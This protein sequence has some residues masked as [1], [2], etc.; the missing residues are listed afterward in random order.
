MCTITRKVPGVGRF[1]V[2]RTKQD[3]LFSLRIKRWHVL[4]HR[5]RSLWPSS[6][7]RRG[8]SAPRDSANPAQRHLSRYHYHSLEGP[9]SSFYRYKTSW[10]LNCSKTTVRDINFAV[11]DRL[12]RAKHWYDTEWCRCA[13]AFD[14]FVIELIFSDDFQRRT[15]RRKTKADVVVKRNFKWY[16]YKPLIVTLRTV[17][18]ESIQHDHRHMFSFVRTLGCNT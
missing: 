3:R 17:R 16:T 5:A 4:S 9:G 12:Y 7:S 15:M 2:F 18:S 8:R 1:T 14:T 13:A 11:V 6:G 10:F